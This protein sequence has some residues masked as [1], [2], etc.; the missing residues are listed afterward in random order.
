LREL[1]GRPCFCAL[2]SSSSRQAMCFQGRYNSTRINFA[3]VKKTW[4]NF[5]APV[6][7]IIQ[8]PH[9]SAHLQRWISTH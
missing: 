5:Q 9:K 8:R 6:Q 3:R 4:N 7:A 1:G 2:A